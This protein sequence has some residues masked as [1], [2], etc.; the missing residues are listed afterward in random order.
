[1]TTKSYPILFDGLKS[2]PLWGDEGWVYLSGKPERGEDPRQFWKLIPTLYRGVDMRARAIGG[3]PWVI[4]QGEKEYESSSNYEN[5]TGL[6]SSMYAM[7]YLI[8]ASLTLA[9]CAYWK[10]EQNAAGYD[11]LRHLDPSSMVLDGKKAQN[12]ELVWK[13]NENGQPKEY[14]PEEIVYLWYLDPYVEIGPPSSWP[15]KSALNACGVLA[16]IDEFAKQYFERGAIKAMLFAMSGATRNQAEEFETWW[17]KFIS[18]LRNVFRTKVINAESV[19]PVVVGEGIAELENVMVTQEKR[20]EIAIALDIKQSLLFA[21]AANYATAERDKLNWYEDFVKTEAN[22]IAEILNEQ[23]FTPL[24]L[25]FR[26]QPE[27]LDIFQ[28]DE[29]ERAEAMSRFIDSAVKAETFEMFQ[30]MLITFGYEVPD[31]AM[32]MIERHFQ[33]MA[34]KPEPPAFPQ[35]EPQTRPTDEP[36][37]E[38]EETN[39]RTIDYQQLSREL[40]IWQSKCL[41]AL[42]RG[43]SVTVPFVPVTIPPDA[44]ERICTGLENATDADSIK[45]VF[46]GAMQVASKPSDNSGLTELVMQ[47]KRQND[48]MVWRGY[49]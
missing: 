16:N 20:E 44:Y 21:D 26:F 38:E 32:Q 35:L 3:L 30:A 37:V 36:E 40:S 31:D 43:E 24:G 34:E 41:K 4:M 7:L 18:G 1:M 5:K 48:I 2:V 46:A 42:K 25:I 28:Q 6:V 47:L 39:V 27:T 11:K 19:T 23:V 15:V 9:G 14:T 45:A 17:N 49:P 12:G 22:F 29:T 13:R 33:K 10:R 8:E